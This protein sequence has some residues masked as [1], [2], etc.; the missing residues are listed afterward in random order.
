MHKDFLAKAENTSA[1]KSQ[2][3]VV[4]NNHI[5]KIKITDKLKHEERC[6]S[7]NIRLIFLQIVSLLL[8]Y[9][10]IGMENTV[11]SDRWEE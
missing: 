1:Q 4:D 3:R 5:C 8:I 10:Q 11:I 2:E 7:L 6:N 9:G